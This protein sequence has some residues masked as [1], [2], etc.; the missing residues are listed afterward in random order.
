MTKKKGAKRKKTFSSSSSSDLNN[1]DQVI[2]AEGNIDTISLIHDVNVLLYG[3][4]GGSTVTPIPT[5]AA[6][7]VVLTVDTDTVTASTPRMTD[8]R[9]APDSTVLIHSKLDFIV[10]KLKKLDVIE[11]SLQ[12][13]S[14][15]VGDLNTRLTS[16]EKK[17]AEFETAVDFFSEKVDEF[18]IK[19][20][21]LDAVVKR[22]EEQNAALYTLK[23]NVHDMDA[24]QKA[25]EGKTNELVRHE[26]MILHLSR[27]VD[28]MRK[29]RKDLQE[30][31]VDLQ[32]RSMKMNL[33]FHGLEGERRG[34]DTERKV[35]VFLREQLGVDWD[36]A[37]ANVHRYGRFVRNKARPIVARFMYQKDLDFV[38]ERSHM[39]RGSPFGISQQFPGVVEERRRVLL[40]IMRKYWDEGYSVKLVRDRL[41]IDGELYDPE[42]DL[43]IQVPGTCNN[44][45]VDPSGDATHPKE[46]DSNG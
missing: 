38:L 10:T 15:I 13:L 32:R 41:Y 16:V 45:D 6:A 43:V 34:E 19:C 26:S 46:S 27:D 30:K 39:L 20:S 1:S 23:S 33:I 25:M 31:V 7:P 44:M 11:E 5:P 37:F 17:S 40:P 24:K 12:K 36:I 28:R 14:I 29:E 35:R 2:N 8:Q 21:K 18:N 4:Q 3:E 9:S 42:D 22:S